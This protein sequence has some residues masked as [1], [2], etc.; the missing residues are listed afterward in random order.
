MG[1]NQ[2]VHECTCG[3]CVHFSVTRLHCIIMS[4]IDVVPS[5]ELAL[6]VTV[7]SPQSPAVSP[8]LLP[9]PRALVRLSFM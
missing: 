9:K 6:T 7:R 5:L 2:E 4:F 3:V 1:A 8:V